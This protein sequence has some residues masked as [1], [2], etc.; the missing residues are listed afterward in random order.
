MFILLRARCSKPLKTLWMFFKDSK[1]Y[2]HERLELHNLIT[3]ISYCCDQLNSYVFT[4]HHY[5]RLLTPFGVVVE[6]PLM[7]P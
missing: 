6:A 3:H 5:H 2:L 1:P 7:I 4:H